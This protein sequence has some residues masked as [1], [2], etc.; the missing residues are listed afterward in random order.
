[1]VLG[2]HG[3]E[4]AADI[5]DKGIVLTGGGSLLGNIDVLLGHA[6]G[7]PVTLAD[8]PLSCVVLGTG[9]CLE[10]MKALKNVLNRQVLNR[11]CS[12][13]HRKEG[14]RRSHNWANRRKETRGR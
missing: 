9:R 1:M 13:S 2:A 11:G 8:E 7:L 14:S 5:V 4:L 6:T 10:E 12:P 3:P